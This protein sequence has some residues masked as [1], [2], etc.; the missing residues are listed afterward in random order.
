MGITQGWVEVMVTAYLDKDVGKRHLC[1]TTYDLVDA[2]VFSSPEEAI[3]YTELLDNLYQ[4]RGV[5]LQVVGIEA[6]EL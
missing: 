2:A 5:I 6:D 4:N 1:E 3:K